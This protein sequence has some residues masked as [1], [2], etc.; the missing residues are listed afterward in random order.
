MK[1]AFYLPTFLG[2]LGR[3]GDE[4]TARAI[5]AEAMAST[6][7][8]LFV[9]S[10]PTQPALER[11]LAEVRGGEVRRFVMRSLADLCLTFTEV[12]WLAVEMTTK[13]IESRS[14]I[15]ASMA[16]IF[17]NRPRRLGQYR[18]RQLAA[19]VLRLRRIGTSLAEICG[20]VRATRQQI[21]RVLV[22]Q[23]EAI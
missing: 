22:G 13:E 14:V 5:H 8:E 12:C 18:H 4:L 1:T 19:K 15:D 11:L 20:L 16:G 9:D 10:D 21:C 3:E 23:G 7:F 6:R 2:P 17:A